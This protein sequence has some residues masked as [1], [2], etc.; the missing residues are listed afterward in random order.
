MTAAFTDFCCRS[1]GNNLNAGTVDGSTTEVAAA[2]LVTYTGGNWTASTD[3]YIAPVGADM[4]QAVVGRFA[5]LYHDGD[6]V[7]TTNQFLIARITNVNAGTRAITLSTTVRV[8]LGTEVVDGT[9]NRSLRIGGAHAGPSG[10]SLFPLNFIT[11]TLTNIAGDQT[12]INLKSDQSYAVTAAIAAPSAAPKFIAGYSS[13]YR[14]GVK[15]TIDGGT[16]GASYVLFTSAGTS[17]LQLRDLEFKNN[18]ATG[19]AALVSLTGLQAS[20]LRCVFHDA[21]GHLLTTGGSVDLEACEFYGANQSNTG[22]TAALNLGAAASCVRCIFHDNTG[23]NT[24]GVQTSGGAYAVSFTDCIFDSNGNDGASTG[25]TSVSATFTRCDFYNNGDRGID[26]GSSHLWVDSCNFVNNTGIGVAAGSGNAY[27]SK[28]G[29]GSGTMANDGGNTS[30]NVEEYG[31]ITYAADMTPWVDPSNG[32]FR[33]NLA[34]AKG[35]GDGTFLQTSASYAGTI[36]YPDVGAGQSIVPTL[37]AA[38]DVESG[39]QYGAGGTEFTGTVTLPSE[40]NV[41]EG[42]TYG[43]GGTEFTGTL[44]PGLVTIVDYYSATADAYTH[45]TGVQDGLYTATNVLGSDY[46]SIAEVGGAIDGYYTFDVLSHSPTQVTITGYSQPDNIKVTIYA[47][48]WDLAQWESLGNWTCGSLASNT[49]HSFP[50]T[51]DHSNSGEVRIRMNATGLASL[52]SISVG[53]IFVLASITA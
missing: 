37:P 35:T 4:T 32:D 39:V 46:H 30:G 29:F 49:T 3:I 26:S 13:T 10:A 24:R 15:V 8:L 48:N 40:S 5:S 12:F 33:I 27:L 23:S 51:E 41:R 9:G 21:R 28:C 14:D 2:P 25:G 45:T 36:G 47:Y 42:T 19:S 18:G 20:A 38:A 50:L 53:R 7:P 34:A 11:S 17:Q 43:A 6:T 31:S 16:S 22:A 52:S 44:E 1:G